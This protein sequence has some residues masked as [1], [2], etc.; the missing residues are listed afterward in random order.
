MLVSSRTFTNSNSTRNNGNTNNFRFDNNH[1]ERN[2]SEQSI[3]NTNEDWDDEIDTN[4]TKQWFDIFEIFY[5]ILFDFC[6][7]QSFDRQDNNPSRS[8]QD[9]TRSSNNSNFSNGNDLG[10]RISRDY[11]I[12]HNDVPRLIGK[13]G[14]NIKQIQR[15][16]AVQI[17][18]SNDRQS[19][20]VDLIISGSNDQDINHTFNHI[21]NMIGNIKEKN[22]LS[23]AKSF[24]KPGILLF[25]YYLFVRSIAHFVRFWYE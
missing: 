23:P 12:D 6:R 8:F 22:D 18:V 1:N 13:G 5:L 3:P 2:Y 11:L 14:V 4:K 17:K 25:F 7:S 19:Q 16:N 20:W 21:K 24:S 15:D 9:S 10:T